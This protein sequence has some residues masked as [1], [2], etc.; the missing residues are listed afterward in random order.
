LP[1]SARIVGVAVG[2]LASTLAAACGERRSEVRTPEPAAAGVSDDDV[3]AL[4]LEAQQLLIA[5]EK[6]GDVKKIA[7]AQEL[8]K[9]AEALEPTDAKIAMWRG[10]ASVMEEDEAGAR[11]A[12]ARIRTR[13]PFGER[14]PRLHYLGALVH[15]IFERKPGE[16]LQAL[17]RAER[18][19]EAEGER[20][21]MPRPAEWGRAFLG[22]SPPKELYERALYRVLRAYAEELVN[23][24]RADEAV[25]ALREAARVARNWPVAAVATRRDLAVVY[26]HGLRWI[27]AEEEWRALVKDFP[28]VADLHRGLA[29][30]HGAQLQYDE[31][32]KEYAEA[33]RLLETGKVP[34]EE[35]IDVL[36]SRLRRGNSLRHLGRLEEARVEIEKYVQEVPD[37]GRGHYW[38]GYLFFDALDRPAD[39]V[40]HL[41][42]AQELLPHCD[43]PLQALLR[44]YEI[45]LGDAAKAAEIRRELEDEAKVRARKERREQVAKEH[46]NRLLC[47]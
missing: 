23:A 22:G 37:D 21:G 28:G 26:S 29:S 2:L 19:A 7:P 18:L 1:V 40:P 31:A 43:E 17:R 10:I 42:R 15:L 27:E 5:V 6:D 35:R 39:A 34:A 25:Q 38:L 47:S 16:A 36:E 45:A 4:L 44:I 14:E 8:L 41:R 12:V 20:L 9:K 33:L 11:A 24:K 46:P 3:K 32:E 13:S 30:V